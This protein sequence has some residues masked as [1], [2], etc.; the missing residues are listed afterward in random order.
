SHFS[1]FDADGE[2]ISLYSF[3]EEAKR[4]KQATAEI[5]GFCLYQKKKYFVRVI[6]QELP[7]SQAAKAKKRKKRKAQK[8]QYQIKE[9]TLFYAN[10]VVLITSLGVEYG[11]EEILSLYQSRWQVELFFKRF[12]QHLSITTIRMGNPTYAEGMV[13]LWLIVWILVEKQVILAEQFLRENEGKERA[14]RFSCW[15]KCRIVFLQ[16]KEILCLSWSLFVDLKENAF[17][18]FL[19]LRNRRRINQNEE[20]HTVILPGLIA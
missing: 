3:L 14:V 18:R 19:S 8:N 2:K 11:M 13:L 5:F 17:H 10:Y 12:K 6:A 7:K 20:F 4:N 1:I 9:E 15:E 16:T